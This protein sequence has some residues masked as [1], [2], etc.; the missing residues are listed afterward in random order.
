MMKFTSPFKEF[1]QRN[2]ITAA[3]VEYSLKQFLIFNKKILEEKYFN[4]EEILE[5]L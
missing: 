4:N 3:M 2:L 5:I 1:Q